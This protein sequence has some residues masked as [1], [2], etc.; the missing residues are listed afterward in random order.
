L[1]KNSGVLLTKK[2]IDSKRIIVTGGAGF[3]GSNLAISLKKKYPECSIIALDNLKRR[4]SELNLQQLKEHEIEFI[5]GDIRNK[6]DLTFDK[7]DI[8]LIIESSAEPSALAGYNSSAEYIINTNL[9]GTANCLELAREKKSDFIFLSTSRVYPFKELN[10]VNF[11]E[12]GSR[13]VITDDQVI[14]GVTSNGISE[15][16]SLDGPKS[17]YGATKLA[18]ELI[19]QEYIDMYGINAVINRCGVIAGP[20]QMGKVDQG[21]FTFWMLKHYFKQDLDYIGFGGKGKQVRDL[22][23]INDVVDLIDREIRNMQLCNGKTYNAGGGNNCSL[24]LLEATK[25]CRK[26]TGNKIDIGKVKKDR[27]ND[28]RIYISDNKKVEKDLGWSAKKTP[29]DIMYDIYTWIVDNSEMIKK[30]IL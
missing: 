13:F 20:C 18:S 17:L 5:H 24:S 16:F 26:I 4:G 25:L 23:H 19:I 11:K 1:N 30:A 10:R 8:S 9:L 28:V 6:E 27:E 29:D 14:H 3:V 7:K 21:V 12:D 22:V 15:T 2:E